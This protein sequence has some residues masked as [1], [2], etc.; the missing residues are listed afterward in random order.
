MKS[1]HDTSIIET[2]NI[3]LV[4]KKRLQKEQEKNHLLAQQFSIENNVK[5]TL[6]VIRAH[7]H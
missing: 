4:D 3:L 5:Q 7:L 2:L 1:P 6:E